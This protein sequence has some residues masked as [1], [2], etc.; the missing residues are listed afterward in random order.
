MAVGAES[1]A[2]PLVG[3][4]NFN[5]GSSHPQP[6]LATSLVLVL[7]DSTTPVPPGTPPGTVILRKA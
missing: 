7:P 1:P 4:Q 2:N 6:V 3:G 5:Y